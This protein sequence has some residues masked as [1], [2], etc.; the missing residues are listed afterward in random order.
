M[1]TTNTLIHLHVLIIL[2]FHW[3]VQCDFLLHDLLCRIVKHLAQDYFVL[4]L[5]HSNKTLL[6]SAGCSVHLRR[7]PP[8]T[9]LTSPAS[10]ALHLNAS[11]SALPAQTSQRLSA[12]ATVLL[13]CHRPH[14]AAGHLALAK[15]AITV[16]LC[17]SVRRLNHPH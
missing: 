7:W 6:A 4:S 3:P 5:R 11:L 2:P 14:R 13:E 12:D 9:M 15:G 1:T 17:E 16:L 10:A 8:S